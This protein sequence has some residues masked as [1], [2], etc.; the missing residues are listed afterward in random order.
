MKNV[1][2]NDLKD[3]K[4]GGMLMLVRWDVGFQK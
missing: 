4:R 1:K 3:F 2:Y